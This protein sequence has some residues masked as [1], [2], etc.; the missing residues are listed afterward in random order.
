MPSPGPGRLQ[1]SLCLQSAPPAQVM[2]SVYGV[3][4]IGAREQVSS[5]LRERGVPDMNEEELFRVSNYAAKVCVA[6]PAA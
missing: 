2:T 6:P 4:H 1:S 5:R 3:T